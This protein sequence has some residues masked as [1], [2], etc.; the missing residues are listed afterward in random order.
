[1][2]NSNEGDKVQFITPLVEQ[3]ATC[4]IEQE[5]ALEQ[6]RYHEGEARKHAKRAK[7]FGDIIATLQRREHEQ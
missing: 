5:E 6:V 3:I 4:I 2:S 1:M 7:S